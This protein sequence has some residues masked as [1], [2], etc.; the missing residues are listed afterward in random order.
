M[1]GGC[2]KGRLFFIRA[3]LHVDKAF[4]ALRAGL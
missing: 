3:A 4:S 1:K 2:P